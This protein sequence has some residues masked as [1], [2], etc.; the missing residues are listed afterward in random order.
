MFILKD[1]LNPLQEAFSSTD[2]GKKLRQWFTYAILA[3]IIPFTTSTSSNVFQC[4]NT[5]FGLNANRRR[6][7]TFMASN[8]LP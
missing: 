2:L 8:K 7:Y 6:F 4:I 3:F 5:L 1:I